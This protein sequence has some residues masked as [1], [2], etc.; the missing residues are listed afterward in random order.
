MATEKEK[1]EEVVVPG[2]LKVSKVITWLLYF[3][4]IIGIIALSLRVF[5]LA[6]SASTVSGFVDFVY[7]LS[8]DYM[9]PFRGIWPPKEVGETG[10]LDIAA[11][12]AIIVYLFIAWG[13]KAL[14]D[15]V[16]NKIDTTTAEQEAELAKVQ[17]QK[18]QAAQKRAAT[19]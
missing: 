8:D 12:F 1:Q 3:W 19:K 18:Q 10:Y 2:Y 11:I 17:R 6:F 16:Q 15:Y 5:L 14:I 7:R 4:V 9:D 13:F